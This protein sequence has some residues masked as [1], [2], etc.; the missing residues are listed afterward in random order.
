ME[1]E[2][3][4]LGH[5]SEELLA[6]QIAQFSMA[7]IWLCDMAKFGYDHSQNLAIRTISIIYLFIFLEYNNRVWVDTL[8][9]SCS[10]WRQGRK[11]GWIWLGFYF[12]QANA[13]IFLVASS[14]KYGEERLVS[15]RQS[16]L[17]VVAAASVSQE[18]E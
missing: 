10:L 6:V 15:N 4:S 13:K 9:V 7:K 17:F 18:T 2:K 3:I 1:K 5:S 11:I 8:P 14:C 16:A 12:A